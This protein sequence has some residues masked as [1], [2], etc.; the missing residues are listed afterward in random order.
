MTRRRERINICET[1]RIYNWVIFKIFFYLPPAKHTF[2]RTFV[3]MF[4][5]VIKKNKSQLNIE[6]IEHT[7][8]VI[9]F[10]KK[11]IKIAFLNTISSTREQTH[12]IE[13]L[14]NAQQTQT[15]CIWTRAFLDFEPTTKALSQQHHHTN[16]TTIKN[17][18][19]STILM[20]KLYINHYRSQGLKL[21]TKSYCFVSKEVCI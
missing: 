4:Q 6:I 15:Q 2:K 5:L 3:Q 20:L 14:P 19:R 13:I 8:C 18:K 10:S 12:S 1:C 16:I 21:L 7:S 9:N 11:C 17:F